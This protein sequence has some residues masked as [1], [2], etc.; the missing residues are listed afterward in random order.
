MKEFRRNL[1]VQGYEWG[2][3]HHNQLKNESVSR[4]R[5]VSWPSI[6]YTAIQVLHCTPFKE[7][8]FYRG[9]SCG[10]VVVSL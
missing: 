4:G 8:L 2:F 7:V 10:C 1:F 5:R 3:N 6:S 9:N